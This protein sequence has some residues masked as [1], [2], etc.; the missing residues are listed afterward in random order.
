MLSRISPRFQ[1]TC[2][3]LSLHLDVLFLKRACSCFATSVSHFP[4][5]SLNGAAPQGGT[6]APG[7]GV[8][9]GGAMAL[10]D[11]AG[12][13]G[14]CGVSDVSHGELSQRIGCC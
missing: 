8:R 7:H 11:A 6:C 2:L 4:A 9:Y 12:S 3:T 1:I 5:F 10:M 13:G 14:C